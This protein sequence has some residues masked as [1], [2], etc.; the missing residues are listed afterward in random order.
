MSQSLV[1]FG[2]VQNFGMETNIIGP[3][4]LALSWTQCVQSQLPKLPELPA[5]VNCQTE[6]QR[7]PIDLTAVSCLFAATVTGR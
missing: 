1:K 6:L 4:L 5:N 2:S 3:L 7:D